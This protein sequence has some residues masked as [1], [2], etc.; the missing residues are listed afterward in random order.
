[1]EV[2]EQMNEKGDVN[3]MDPIE[4]KEIKEIKEP[5][6]PKEP[7]KNKRKWI[8][9]ILILLLLLFMGV[10]VLHEL[11]YVRFPW[12]KREGILVSGNLFPD[13]GD[14]EDGGLS[15]MSEEDLMAQMQKVADA[16]YF[17]FKINAEP[18]FEDGKS[19]GTLGIENPNYNVYP[20]VVQIKLDKTGELLYD[21]GGILPNQ[22]ID[23]AK[24]TKVLKA[25]THP[26]TAYLQAYHPDT[27]EFIFEQVVVLNIVVK[28]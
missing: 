14:A 26:A 2:S 9:R 23:S 22:H 17:S 1:M 25:G 15:N 7:K 8:I 21:S 18:V 24:L 10:L 13:G 3:K 19:E 11:G 5:K 27:E 12:D 16:S 6:E 28:K 20:M 4:N